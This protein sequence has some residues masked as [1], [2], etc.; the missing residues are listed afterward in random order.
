MR[1]NDG[2]HCPHGVYTVRPDGGNLKQITRGCDTE[3]AW[4]PDGTRLAF[5]RYRGR[6][7]P[8]ELGVIPAR[9]GR[10]QRI[11]T[12]ASGAVEHLDWQPLPR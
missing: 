2:H 9:G 5:V 6:E 12:S 1:A 4:S 7:H 11:A 3:V 10:A 8:D